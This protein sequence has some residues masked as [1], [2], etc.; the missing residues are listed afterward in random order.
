MEN[1]CVKDYDESGDGDVTEQEWA[2]RMKYLMRGCC[3]CEATKPKP[4]LKV[5][6]MSGV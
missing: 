4:A 3:I 6:Q 2:Q 5:G 1:V